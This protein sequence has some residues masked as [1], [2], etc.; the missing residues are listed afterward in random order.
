VSVLRESI[1]ADP[2]ALGQAVALLDRL[3]WQ[4]PAMVEFKMDEATGVPVLMEINGRF[5]GS[6][7]L[8]IDAGVD[9]P[10]LLVEAALGGDPEPVTEYRHGVRTRWLLGDLDHLLIR[11]RRSAAALHL[12]PGAPGRVR[13]VAGFVGGFAPPTRLEVLRLRDLRPFGRELRIW[14]RELGG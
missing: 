1:A 4:G 13:T 7:Q 11:L 5:W 8:A 14:L 9:F 3:D 6:L 10:A 2:I 12:P